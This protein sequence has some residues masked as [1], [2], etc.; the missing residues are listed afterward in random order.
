MR[1][2]KSSRQIRASSDLPYRLHEAPGYAEL[3]LENFA[4]RK[5]VTDL[6]L[7]K[8]KLEHKWQ[9]NS[10]HSAASKVEAHLERSR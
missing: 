4:L 2:D 8:M 5:L 3:E 7:E 1:N 9:Q 6:Q 10:C